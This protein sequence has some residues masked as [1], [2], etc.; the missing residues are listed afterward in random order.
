MTNPPMI[1][2]EGLLIFVAMKPTVRA[3]QKTN[4]IGTDE[5]DHVNEVA[6][7]IEALGQ[8]CVV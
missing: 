2:F 1:A 4:T 5:A 6:I 7:C 8:I 3:S